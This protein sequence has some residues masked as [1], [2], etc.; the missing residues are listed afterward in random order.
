MNKLSQDQQARVIACLC[1][2]NSLRST[3]RLVDCSI[4]A[5]MRTFIKLGVANRASAILRNPNSSKAAKSVAASALTQVRD[6]KNR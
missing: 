1:E 4:N 3:A 2:G 6:K 5:V